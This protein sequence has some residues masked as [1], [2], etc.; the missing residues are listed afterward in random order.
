M[1]EEE[2]S[3]INSV[4]QKKNVYKLAEFNKLVFA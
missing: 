3:R 2:N 1:I 4:S